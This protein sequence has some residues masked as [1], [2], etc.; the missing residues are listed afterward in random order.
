MTLCVTAIRREESSDE[1]KNAPA[2]T[3]VGLELT[4]GWYRIRSNVDTTL[5]GACQRGRIVV[6]SKLSIVGAKVSLPT[7]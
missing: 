2:M 5:Q 3:I 1:S 6:G 4:D 7:S